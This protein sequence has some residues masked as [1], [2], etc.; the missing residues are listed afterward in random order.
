MRFSL[1]LL[2]LLGQTIF[3]KAADTLTVEQCRQLAV[4]TSPLQQKKALADSRAALQ[5]D[6]TGTNNLPHISIGGQATWQSAVFGIPIE[7]PFFKIPKVPKDQYKLTLDASERIWDGN[8]DHYLREQQGLERDLTKAQTDVDVFQLRDLVTDLYIKT[9]LLQESEA[10]LVASR[11]DLQNRLKQTESMVQE[12]IALRT[13]ADQVRIQILKTDQQIGSTRADKVTLM[14]LLAAWIGRQQVDFALRV[15]APAGTSATAAADTRPEYA[16]FSLQQR[17][18]QLGKDMLHLRTLPRFDAFMQSGLGKPNP[19]NFFETGFK[20]FVLLGLKATWT[21][22]DWGNRSRESQ[23]LELQGKGVDIQR[24]ALDQRLENAD[25]KDREDALKSKALL[26]QDDAIIALQ[27][28]I[29]RRAET[30]VKEGVM[31][32][33]DYLTQLSILTQAKLSRKTHEIQAIASYETSN[34]RRQTSDV[35]R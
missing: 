18:V 7:S 22:I 15:P 2:C 31:T 3:A 9:L 8:T 12:G 16:L 21:P 33:T 14:K 20:P 35:G 29:I 24:Q 10:V 30:Q 28:D 13:M 6:N 32:T 4:K 11:E 34:A 23:M 1:I 19:F 26:Q 5:S 17:S 27:E 25:I